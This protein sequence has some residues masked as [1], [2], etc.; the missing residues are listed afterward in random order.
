MFFFSAG[1]RE[2]EPRVRLKEEKMDSVEAEPRVPS[3]VM[4][5]PAADPSPGP[6]AERAS[7]PSSSLPFTPVVIKQEPQ[8][9]IN[10]SSEHDPADDITHC[11]HSTTPELPVASAAAS[12]SGNVTQRTVGVFHFV[13][14]KCA[15]YSSKCILN[16]CRCCP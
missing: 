6:P 13:S 10:V 11:A 15:V 1:I 3:S 9:P 5:S 7:P 8:S 16:S 12:P 4:D 14:V 2:E